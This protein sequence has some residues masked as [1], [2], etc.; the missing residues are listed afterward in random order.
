MVNLR[1]CFH[2]HALGEAAWA[3]ASFH[4]RSEGVI[5]L[6]EVCL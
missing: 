5:M 6:A 1:E 2:Q 4:H 3:A